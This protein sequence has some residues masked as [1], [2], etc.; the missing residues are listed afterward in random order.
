MTHA[1]RLTALTVV[2]AITA[3]V[4]SE[5]QQAR[6]PYRIGV[7]HQAFF[8]SIPSVEGLK[9][10]LKALGLEEGRDVTFDIRFTRGNLLATTA[11]ATALVKEGVDLIF[12]FDEYPTQVTR[13]ATQRIPIVFSAVGDP[14][15]AGIVKEIAYP[16]G[17]VTG[18]YSLTTELVP[19][20]LEILKAIVPSLRR[21]W[22]VYH[23][24][25]RSSAAAARKAQEVAP[26]LK[27]EVLARGVRTPEELVRELKGLRPGDGLLSPPTVTL[28]IP[29][30]MLDLEFSGRWPLV[31]FSTFWAQAG[32]LVSYG[33]DLYADGIQAAR[34]V[35]KILMAARPQ[36]VPVE[37]ANKIE[38]AINLKTAR[39]LGVTIPRELL[40]RADHVI[41]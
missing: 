26:L 36:D 2:L 35:V 3:A 21:V 29:G 14:V 8:Q 20:R 4:A 22:A 10:G 38:L 1:T 31:S 27:L 17:N 32:A 5:A 30:V 24:D 18:V 11:Q 9:A 34:L 13:A 15:A 25:D 39:S 33:S 7:L 41:E 37:G 12:T 23:A 28:N 16:G 6:R 19:K 40:A